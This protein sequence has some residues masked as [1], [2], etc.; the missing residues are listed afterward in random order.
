MYYFE[1]KNGNLYFKFRKF[2]EKQREINKKFPTPFEKKVDRID[3]L[4][5]N[6]LEEV[7]EEEVEYGVIE[8]NNDTN[9][10]NKYNKWMEETVDVIMYLGSLYNEINDLKV[11]NIEE[12]IQVDINNF[13]YVTNI[14]INYVLLG[15]MEIRRKFPE[16]KWH[17]P[18]TEID[19]NRDYDSLV[20]IKYTIINIIEDNFFEYEPY[21]K[22]FDKKIFE[23]EQYI[24]NLPTI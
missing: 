5:L 1:R 14:D 15:L 13:I 24:I 21:L 9:D 3:K 16:R 22:E 17:K 20:I 18:I 10:I 8:Y 23:K 4:I 2:I 11:D 6:V 12:K 19:K 7:Y